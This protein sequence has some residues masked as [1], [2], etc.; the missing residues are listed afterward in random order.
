MPRTGR[1]FGLFFAA[2]GENTLGLGTLGD[3][4]TLDDAAG[5]ISSPKRGVGYRLR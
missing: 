3:P 4:I 2:D 5:S 1:A